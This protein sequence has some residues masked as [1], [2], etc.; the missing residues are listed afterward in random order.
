MSALP[1]A[2]HTTT[3]TDTSFLHV[4][5]QTF[6][7][8]NELS[9]KVNSLK[10]HREFDDILK[11]EDAIRK[12]LQDIP[13]WTNPR[14]IQARTL[15]DLQLRQFLVIVHA[16]RA[17]KYEFR[18]QSDCRYSMMTALEAA[19]KTIELHYNVTKAS[20]YALILT[21]NDYFRATLLICHIAYYA[22][23]ANG[24]LQSICL[25]L[26]SLTCLVDTMISRIAKTIF[27]ESVEKSLRLQEERV[28]RPGRGSEYFWYISAAIS[29]VGIQFNPSQ[30]DT[31]KRQAMDRVAKLLYRVLSLQ[32]DPSDETLASE[33]RYHLLHAA[34]MA[35]PDARLG[36]SRVSSSYHGCVRFTRF[37]RFYRLS[38]S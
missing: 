19:A 13:R 5:M 20:N 24:T 3:Y 22:K 34:I 31:L 36:F 30:S 16:S 15:L 12:C 29:L 8:R 37:T 10:E 35:I 25:I 6:E 1:H 32:D 4:A 7:C 14:S 27:D 33:V 38:Y 28:M 17:V 23:R 26:P 2:R 21:R 18:T 9:S 11:S